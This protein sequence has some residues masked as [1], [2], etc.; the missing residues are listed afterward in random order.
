VSV[1]TR[2]F[3]AS[4]PAFDRQPT[5][6]LLRVPHPLRVNAAGNCRLNH[7]YGVMRGQSSGADHSAADVHA[8]VLLPVITLPRQR[9]VVGLL[10]LPASGEMT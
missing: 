3:L 10:A 1:I 8:A 6:P 9:N 7:P 2:S 5:D 4:D